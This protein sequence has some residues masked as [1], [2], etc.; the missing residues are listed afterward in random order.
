MTMFTE[1]DFNDL[2][3][4]TIGLWAKKYKEILSVFDLPRLQDSMQAFVELENADED[5][6]LTTASQDTRNPDAAVMAAFDRLYTRVFVTLY[7]RGVLAPFIVVDDVPEGA[8]R[9]LDAMTEEVES[10][11]SRKDARQQAPVAPVVVAENPV[12][13]CIQDF[14]EMGSN[15]FKAKY[16]SNTKNRGYYEAAIADGRI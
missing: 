16:L 2:G 10:Y 12:D 5:N 15:A 1:H 11:R 13:R 14:H 7:D 8:Q 3:G 4:F 9:Q 6:E